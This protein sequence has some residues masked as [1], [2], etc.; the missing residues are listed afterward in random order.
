MNDYFLKLTLLAVILLITPWLCAFL[1]KAVCGIF[2]KYYSRT[3]IVDHEKILF[4]S[5]SEHGPNFIYHYL[6]V[7]V[8]L[9]IIMVSYF[10]NEWK[11]G[12][13]SLIGFIILI[14]FYWNSLTRI[15]LSSEGLRIYKM[16]FG[17]D[18]ELHFFKQPQIKSVYEMVT[19]GQTFMEK[20][21]SWL[22]IQLKNGQQ[23]LVLSPPA[24]SLALL[25]ELLE[26]HDIAIEKLA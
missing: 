5:W 3:N 14:L 13:F 7:A 4:S 12:F 9:I 21:N 10:Q 18:T 15:E 8:S 22:V 6:L 2:K 20:L 25:L 11:I 17:A 24:D 19:V 1:N 23:V 26:A 16:S